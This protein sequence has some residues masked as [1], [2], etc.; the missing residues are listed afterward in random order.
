MKSQLCEGWKK[1]TMMIS[2]FEA[3]ILGMGGSFIKMERLAI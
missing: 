2:W 3:Q 1:E